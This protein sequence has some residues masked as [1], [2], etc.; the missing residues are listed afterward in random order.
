MNRLAAGATAFVTRAGKNAVPLAGTLVADWQAVVPMLLY[1]VENVVIVLLAALA[2]RILAPPSEVIDGA[3][4]HRGESLKTFF[5]LAGPFSFGAAVL[6]GFV[7]LQ[8]RESIPSGFI[9]SVAMILGFQ[10]VS[11]FG[12]LMNLRGVTLA[13]AEGMLVG[14]LGRVFLLAF[15]AFVGIWAAIL[16]GMSAFVIPFILLK[17][18]ADLA[19]IRPAGMKT[20]FLAA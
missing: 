7:M 10:F 15:A 2:V 17:T 3:T 11:F 1:L 12:D 18:L 20:R 9:T 13:T 5:L 8:Q 14:V 4:K 16:G 6:T 19:G